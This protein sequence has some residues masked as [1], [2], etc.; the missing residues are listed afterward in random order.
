MLYSLILAILLFASPV[1]GVVDPVGWWKFDAGSGTSAIDSGSGGHNGTL[2]NSATWS[3][4]GQVGASSLSTNG[5][6]GNTVSVGDFSNL[7]FPTGNFSISLWFK[8]SDETITRFL[9]NKRYSGSCIPSLDEGYYVLIDGAAGIITSLCD[10]NGVSYGS[11]AWTGQAN[12]SWHHYVVLVDTAN[13][14]LKAYGDNA[15]IGSNTDIT[16]HSSLATSTGLTI[17]GSTFQEAVWNGQIDDVRIYNRV[18]T[19]TEIGNIYNQTEGTVT[20]RSIG[21]I[22]VW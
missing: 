1:W 5:T 13:N 14:L 16:G 11:A 20:K 8:T 4:P 22:V 17:A 21:S 2:E 7:D 10:S 3:S 18:I 15:L 12:G 6:N 9:L 19:T